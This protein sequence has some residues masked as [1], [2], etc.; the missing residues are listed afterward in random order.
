MFTASVDILRIAIKLYLATHCKI[1]VILLDE[2]YLKKLPFARKN[3]NFMADYGSKYHVFMFYPSSHT[4]RSKQL[5]T[6]KTT[7]SF[8]LAL[9]MPIL[10]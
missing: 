7:I 1:Y 4:A 10:L 2:F 8:G 3:G 9:K 5:A 6:C